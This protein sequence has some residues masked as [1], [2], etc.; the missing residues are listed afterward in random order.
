[1]F[2]SKAKLSIINFAQS[3]NDVFDVEKNSL[4]QAELDLM[5]IERVWPALIFTDTD[6]VYFNFL[7]IYKVA[8]PKISEEHYQNWVREMILMHNYSRIDSSNLI[9]SPFR[10]IRNKKNLDMF[11][12][13]TDTPCL[14][15]IIANNPKEYIKLFDDGEYF[16]RHKGIPARVKVEFQ[17]YLRRVQPFSTVFSE[18]DLIT[19]EKVS[20]MTLKYQ[21]KKTFLINNVKTNLAQLSDKVYILKDGVQTLQHGHV[22]LKEIYEASRGK[23]SEELQ[24][25]KHLQLLCSIEEEIYNKHPRLAI[26]NKFMRENINKFNVC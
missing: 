23:T 26:Y 18:Q 9:H 20:Y 5:E 10:E 21:K 4:L 8:N 24:T 11:Q 14:K 7:A 15:Q 3:I 6:S 2:F 16:A 25:D 12:F 22:L 17:S 19:S 13:K 1:M